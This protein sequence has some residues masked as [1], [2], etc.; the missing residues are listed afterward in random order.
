MKH[1]A[2]VFDTTSQSVFLLSKSMNSG[3]LTKTNNK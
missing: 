1:G 2:R 3:V